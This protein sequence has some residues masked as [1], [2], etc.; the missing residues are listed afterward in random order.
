MALDEHRAKFKVSRWQRQDRAIDQDIYINALNRPVKDKIPQPD[1]FMHRLGHSLSNGN[2]TRHSTEMNGKAV[3]GT[4]NGNTPD[5]SGKSKQPESEAERK[6]RMQHAGAET[7][8]LEVWF[9]GC[10]ADVG[11]GESQPARALD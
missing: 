9:M 4:P 1:G 6:M 2:K 7:D 10:H 11:G 8:V 3:N 5:A